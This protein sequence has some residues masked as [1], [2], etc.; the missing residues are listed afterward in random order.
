MCVLWMVCY[1]NFYKGDLVFVFMRDLCELVGDDLSC[2][3]SNVVDVEYKEICDSKDGLM[4]PLSACFGSGCGAYALHG[5]LN[6]FQDW[7]IVDHLYHAAGV[8]EM[9]A[10][11]VIAGLGFLKILKRG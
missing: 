11:G 8:S 10:I 6:M 9:G 4:F 5:T 7:S 1:N 2:G 3:D